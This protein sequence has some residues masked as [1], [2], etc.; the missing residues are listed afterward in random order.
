MQRR[1]SSTIPTLSVEPLERRVLLSDVAIVSINAKQDASESDPFGAGVGQFTVRRT[2][3]TSRPLDVF[4]RFSPGASTATVGADLHPPVKQVRIAVGRVYTHFSI[5]PID[6]NVHDPAETVVMKLFTSDGYTIN[7]ARPAARI[8]IADNDTLVNLFRV[9]TTASES[10]P[11]GAGRG[12]FRV[13]RLGPT[14]AT[15]DVH[16]YVHSTS[17][18][19]GGEDFEPLPGAVTIPAGQRTADFDLIPIDDTDLEE[20]E[21]VV[22]ALR[23]DTAYT[24]GNAITSITILDNDQSREGWW[25]DEWKF[26]APLDVDVRSQRRTDKPV[27]MPINFTQLL[28]QLGRSGTLVEESIRVVETTADGLGVLDENVP[29]QFDEA[30]GYDPTTAAAGNLVFLLTGETPANTVRHYHV[31]FDTSGSFLPPQVTPRID[32]ADDVFDEGQS[33]FRIATPAATYFYQKTGAGFS[34]ILDAGGNDWLNFNPAPGSGSSGEWRGIPN[35]GAAFHPGY[36]NGQT[37]LISAGPL[38]V[39]LESMSTDGLRRVRWDFY[40]RYATMSVLQFTGTYWFLYEGTPGGA[41]DEDDYVVRSDGTRTGIGERWSEP[42]GIG[43][44]NGQSWVYF[45]DEN[46]GRYLFLAHHEGDDLEDSYYNLDNNMTVFGFGRRSPEGAP[47]ERLMSGTGNT[48]T[49]GIADGG[50]N[51]SNASAAINGAYRGLIVTPASP[52]PRGQ[53]G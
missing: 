17:T 48:F 37:E 5:I 21:T 28:S 1:K 7:P 44:V 20:S 36:E 45:G 16:Y 50:G 52:Q 8:R 42:D 39:T 18:A 49:I 9:T 43:S 40:P 47:A 3:D 35:M 6:D 34:S 25:N 2:G 22:L 41:M 27:D 33:S 29:F 10:D 31:Y 32:L 26:R 15:L 12:I 11:A 46:L 53:S 38:K 23:A 51:V 13:A 14:D 4:V 30:P 19:V 24:R